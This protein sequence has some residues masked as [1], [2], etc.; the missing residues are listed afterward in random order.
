MDTR[1][2]GLLL[3]RV[4][5]LGT[6]AA[7]L[8]FKRGTRYLLRMTEST[9]SVL[10]LIGGTPLLSLERLHAGPGTILAK[11]EFVQPGGSVKDR[12]ALR[13]IQ[14]A[15]ASGRL[16]PGQPVVEMTSGNMGAG[17]AVVCSVFGHHLIA[18]MSEGNSRAR[19]TMLEM[20]GA[21]VILVPQVEG[22]PG[23]VTGRDIGAAVVRAE[24]RARDRGAYYV[25]QFNNPPC[26]LAHEEGTAPEIDAAAGD[27]LDAFVTC[28]GTGGT[29][30]GTSRYL[31]RHHPD[32]RCYA[33][34]PR[35]AEVLAG[36]DMTKSCHLLQG[37]GY[38][39]VPPQWDPDLTDGFLTV[40]DEEATEFRSRLAE[41]EGLFVG[42]SAAANVCAAVK[43]I[44]SGVLRS[45]PV[46]ATILCDSGLK[47]L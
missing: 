45:D 1:F 23:R 20:L 11:A 12:A 43:L 6:A 41:L 15:R 38:G 40:S 28:V 21:E 13:I 44:G 8:A 19:A 26:V 18:T 29:F 9:A 27:R 42:Y 31:K 4:G 5:E 35:G 36:G 2:I 17:L 24:E 32:L 10:G 39:L 47:Y 7:R 33:V 25:D 16:T 34:E 46:V 14:D 37:T 30:I 3:N 22:S